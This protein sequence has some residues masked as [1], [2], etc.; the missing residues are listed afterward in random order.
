MKTLTKL[1]LVV[2]ALAPALTYAYT[3]PR[4][5]FGKFKHKFSADA[6]V[7][8]LD[9]DQLGVKKVLETTNCTLDAAGD[10][11][12]RSGT[13]GGAR[14]VSND[15]CGNEV[16]LFSQPVGRERGGELFNY[17]VVI[18]N[19]RQVSVTAL[20]S[21]PM[22]ESVKLRQLSSKSCS[23]GLYVPTESDA[24]R[25]ELSRRYEV[26]PGQPA[27][28]VVEIG[29]AP[30][31]LRRETI[32]VSGVYSRFGDR[33]SNFMPFIDQD[34]ETFVITEDS[35]CM[36][37]EVADNAVVSARFE[38]RVLDNGTSR[39]TCVSL[40]PRRTSSRTPR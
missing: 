18:V 23:V 4:S 25:T 27:E 2:S 5:K 40:T 37:V 13:F 36:D 16:H 35:P 32:A 15:A 31:V 38:V 12:N 39:K 8:Y 9:H 22:L 19:D 28:L 7:V 14:Q 29:K 26:K 11:L 1:L 20:E 33:G 10:Q 24:A 30:R 3:T 34:G 21:I 17:W 6:C